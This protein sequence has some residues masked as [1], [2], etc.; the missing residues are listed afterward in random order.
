MKAG[1]IVFYND[2]SHTD[3]G[4]HNMIT[5]VLWTESEDHPFAVIRFHRTT[6]NV[7][8]K[9]LTVLPVSREHPLQVPKKPCMAISK[10]DGL[11]MQEYAGSHN[12]EAPETHEIEIGY[13]IP[14]GWG[15]SCH[16]NQ[17]EFMKVPLSWCA[18]DV[19]EEAFT[20]L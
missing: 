13:V 10:L 8:K 20:V 11:S 6:M 18:Y 3:P 14:K 2:P 15:I 9:H 5:E 16:G 1:D 19:P 4:F 17:A 12:G 7:R